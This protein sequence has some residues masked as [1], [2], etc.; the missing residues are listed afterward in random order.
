MNIAK[1]MAN[2]GNAKISCIEFTF[3]ELASATYNFNLDSL[4]G[5]GG[6]GRVY[7][8]YLKKLERVYLR[9]NNMHTCTQNLC[10]RYAHLLL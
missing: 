5:E 8:G 2:F 7:K 4:V 1:D 3:S 6:F 10:R 9:H